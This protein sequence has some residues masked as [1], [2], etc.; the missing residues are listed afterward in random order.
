MTWKKGESGNPNGRPT[1]K[2]FAEAVR[3]A[4]LDTDKA[5]GCIRLRLIAEQL[6]TKALEGDGWAIQTIADRLD[7][8]PA[9]ESN[10][11]VT[12]RTIR[13][14]SDLELAAR[15]AGL[16]AGNPPAQGDPEEPD[17]VVLLPRFPARPPP[18]AH[19]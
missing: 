9:Q 14:L 19:H 4:V 8:K 7:G 3:R 18:P 12:N 15:I 1:E 10:V 6:V 16:L 2:V 5:T 11:N 17:G 13:E